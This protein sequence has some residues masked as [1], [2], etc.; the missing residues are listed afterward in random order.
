MLLTPMPD[1]KLLP[2]IA[3]TDGKYA[4]SYEQD[5][6]SGPPH[7]LIPPSLEVLLPGRSRFFIRER[8][9]SLPVSSLLLAEITIRELAPFIINLCRCQERT[10]GSLPQTFGFSKAFM[11][12]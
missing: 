12:S 4:D 5:R 11:R 9:L 2:A 1:Q 10:E 3:T 7:K 8:W 6:L